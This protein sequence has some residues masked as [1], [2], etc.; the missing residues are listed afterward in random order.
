MAKVRKLITQTGNDV[1]TSVGIETGLT[2]D[3][4]AAWNILGFKAYWVDGAG[5]AA[6]D[7][8]LDALV[9]SDGNNHTFIDDEWIANISWGVQNTGGVAV[10]VQY[11]PFKTMTLEEERI[12]VQPNI[13]LGI[14]SALTGQANDVIFE[15]QYEIVKITDLEVL[16]LLA[17]GA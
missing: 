3:G 5:V 6:A 15:L 16:R 17:G 4:K 2:V 13:Y 8:S 1:F 11:E 14:R 7:W 12:T 9:L 10:A